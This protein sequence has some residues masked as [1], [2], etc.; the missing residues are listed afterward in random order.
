MFVH[1]E[2][3]KIDCVLKLRI[4]FQEI[5]HAINELA[6][7]D[8]DALRNVRLGELH[9]GVCVPALEDMIADVKVLR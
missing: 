5:K 2:L 7:L 9:G 8:L 3:D 6:V 4:P 1:I